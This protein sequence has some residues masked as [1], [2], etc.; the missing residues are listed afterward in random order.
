MTRIFKPS[1][2]YLDGK[3]EENKGIVVEKG[4]IIDIDKITNLLKKYSNH[5]R[6][7]ETDACNGIQ[8]F[9]SK[10]KENIQ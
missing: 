10:L 3:F 5:Y 8:V 4:T 9:I 6:S 7:N 2:V 1:L